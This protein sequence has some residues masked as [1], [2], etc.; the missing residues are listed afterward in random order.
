MPAFSE[1]QPNAFACP[2]S[3]KVWRHDGSALMPA[4]GGAVGDRTQ[5]AMGQGT[6][7]EQ[8]PTPQ[9]EQQQQ[10]QPGIHH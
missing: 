8:Q 7:T 9:P 10:E 1:T 2:F 5:A 3:G 4:P 6:E